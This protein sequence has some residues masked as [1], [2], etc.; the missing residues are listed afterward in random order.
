MSCTILSFIN[1]NSFNL[2]NNGMCHY[3]PQGI[4]PEETKAHI[5]RNLFKMTL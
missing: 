2:P 5:L 3:H 4:T 1:I